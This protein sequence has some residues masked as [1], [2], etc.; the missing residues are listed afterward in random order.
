MGTVDAPVTVLE[1]GRIR[2]LRER[3]TPLAELQV[4]EATLRME[5]GRW[6]VTLS[7]AGSIAGGGDGA[8][9]E[10]MKAHNNGDGSACGLA[11]RVWLV[12]PE[13]N[14]IRL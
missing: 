2:G 4:L 13:I 11:A 7:P 1:R 5:G 3:E 8:S 6:A 14:Y 9:V 10:A 12:V